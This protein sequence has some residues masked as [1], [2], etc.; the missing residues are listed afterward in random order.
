MNQHEI[1]N[2]DHKLTSPSYSR[3]HNFVY[4]KAKGSY[5]YDTK[6]KK[7]LDF[8]AGI[9]V[10]NVGHTNP[11]VVQAIKKQLQL[12]LHAGFPD[13]YATTPLEFL[14]KLYQFLP[15][16]LNKSFFT[17]SGTESVEAALKVAK[18]HTKKKWLFSFKGG[19]H[20]RTLGSLT[21]TNSKPVQRER[22]EPFYP[23]KHSPYP[24]EYRWNNQ[25][26]YKS[27]T[28]DCLDQFEKTIKPIKNDLAA[29]F[30]EPIQGE[31]GYIVPPK[32][33]VKGI[34]KICT[35]NNI[36]LCSD[37]VQS[38]IFRTGKFLAIE[39]YNVKPDIITL[40][41]AIGGGIPFGVMVTSSK[42]MDWVQSAHSNTFGGNL[43]ACAA[44]KAVLE[45]C[46]KKKLD[47]NAIKVGNY[48]KN[49]LNEMKDKYEI[50]GDVRGIGLMIGL[51]IVKNQKTKEF[52]VK[53]R[54]KIIK[55]GSNQGLIL[56][57][58]GTSVIRISPP[59]TLTLQEA[60]KGL[61]ILETSIKSVVIH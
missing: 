12:G 17:N 52:G 30:M 38:G 10:M 1:I 2:L 44:G 22:F 32:E 60:E 55:S 19:F 34:K 59:L 33:F 42:I 3:D 37:E 13:F 20:G 46:E 25:K 49:R 61:N 4:K 57:P 43:I 26:N 50:I 41:K 11:Y 15:K 29:V 47:Q 31:G 39:N 56:L 6:N 53:E 14:K 23:A 16:E 24:Y 21:L 18:W 28:E 58:C 35:E 36:L 27:V 5:I 54:E 45:Y 7:Y 48:I 51:E 9:A 8:A 40:A